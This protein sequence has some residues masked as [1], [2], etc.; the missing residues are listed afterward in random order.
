MTRT[1]TV[2]SGREILG[3]TIRRKPSA[4]LGLART[5]PRSRVGA[6]PASASQ[7]PS[8]CRSMPA[9]RSRNAW[10]P[11]P[12]VSTRAGRQDR[13]EAGQLSAAGHD[14]TAHLH[15]RAGR[16]AAGE[17]GDEPSHDPVGAAQ[18]Q[19]CSTCVPVSFRPPTKARARRYHRDAED[20]DPSPN[21]PGCPWWCDG[22]LRDDREGQWRHEAVGRFCGQAR[23]GW[24][25]RGE[26]GAHVAARSLIVHATI[27]PPE[28]VRSRDFR[29]SPQIFRPGGPG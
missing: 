7:R 28:L 19:D 18:D 5:A 9:R 11:L 29:V 6:S 22:L 24:Q 21:S 23:A 20:G 14:V 17:E 13:R 12:L 2:P 27:E 26:E 15:P 16:V 3:S 8:A 1:I 25:V 10:I 4:P